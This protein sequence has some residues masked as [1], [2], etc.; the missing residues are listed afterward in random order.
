MLAS[1]GI[2][3]YYSWDLTLVTLAALPFA[4]LLLSL[5][6]CSIQP[7]NAAQTEELSKA[8]QTASHTISAIETVKTCNGQYQ[9]LDIYTKIVRRAGTYYLA[10][11]RAN[12][13]QIGLVRLTILG[14]FVQGFWYGSHLVNTA[15]KSPGDVLTAFWAALMATQT[16]EQIMPQFLVMEKGRAA[17]ST[18]RSIACS[19]E[20]DFNVYT[21]NTLIPKS[22]EGDIEMKNVSPIYSSRQSTADI[23]PG[24]H[25][26]SIKT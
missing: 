1:L 21:Q 4:A 3:F 5:A 17:G 9:E 20:A 23:P 22:C 15:Q 26:L 2:A 25:L 14:M 6:S 16:V 11:A 18:L 13:A 7:N 10:T 12:A 8:S 19:S 24:E